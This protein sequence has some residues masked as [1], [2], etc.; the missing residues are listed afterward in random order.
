MKK[1]RK[2]YYERDVEKEEEEYVT[3]ATRHNV[4]ALD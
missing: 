3:L 1:R 4:F 2:I